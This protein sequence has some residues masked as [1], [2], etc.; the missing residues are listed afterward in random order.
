[1]ATLKLSGPQAREFSAALR[2][3]FSKQR[4]DEMLL[5]Y[6]NIRRE[7]ISLGDDLQAIV[8]ALLRDADSRNY[9]DKLL[10]AA[11]QANPESSELLAFGAKF[12]LAPSVKVDNGTQTQSLATPGLERK[13]VAANGNKDVTPWRNKLGR[14]EGRICRVEHPA[15]IGTGFLVANDVVM[16]NY[17]V[18]KDVI[19]GTVKSTE[20]RLRFDYRRLEGDIVNQ[21]TI[22]SLSPSWD[23]YHSEFSEMDLSDPPPE[24]PAWD[25]LDLALLEVAG[26]PGNDPVGGPAVTDPG[27]EPRGFVPLP[28]TPHDFEKNPALFIL[29]HPDG[30]PLALAL[31]TNA[32]IW[33]RQTRVRYRTNTEPGSSGSPCF[34]ADWNLVA[35]HHAGDTRWIPTYNQGIPLP[36][37]LRLLEDRRVLGRLGH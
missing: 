9:T 15:A 2:A 22:Y 18:M 6:L 32:V 11:R 14:L 34:D 35:L 30:E 13:I 24:P 21:G 4:L 23:I 31:D 37:I 17:H 12:G 16:T 20:V 25:K 3:A 10:I 36:A 1:M 27:A 26:A 7:D 8:F 19:A 28:A 29:Q 33:A 5:Y